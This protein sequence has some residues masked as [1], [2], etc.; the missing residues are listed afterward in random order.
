VVAEYDRLRSEH[1]FTRDSALKVM[2]VHLRA[3]ADKL[4][5]PLSADAGGSV[6]HLISGHDNLRCTCKHLE[7]GTIGECSRTPILYMLEAFEAAAPD[8]PI[9]EPERVRASERRPPASRNDPLASMMVEYG[10]V[11]PRKR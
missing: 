11:R 10:I 2:G 1:G 6:R 8:Y 9:V 4:R 5:V 3:V 7:D